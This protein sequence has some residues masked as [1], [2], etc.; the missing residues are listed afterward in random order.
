VRTNLV[1]AYLPLVEKIAASIHRSINQNV[2]LDE[3]VSMG[4]LGLLDAASRIDPTASTF[5]SYA[6]MRIRGTI[7]DSLGNTA[8]LPRKTHR[9]VRAGRLHVRPIATDPRKL[10]WV[11]APHRCP[12]RRID[13]ERAIR[14]LVLLPAR[15]RDMLHAIYFHDRSLSELAATFG[16][17]ISRVSRLRDQGLR[18][19][20]GLLEA[21]PDASR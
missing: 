8:P 9:L 14:A 19:L 2:E 7:L 3:L 6:Y 17:S 11:R 20:R 13:G 4:V 5:D 21:G 10:E 12:A 16:L 15:L 1:D 18:Q